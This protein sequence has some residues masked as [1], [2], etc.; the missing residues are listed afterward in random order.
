M[1]QQRHSKVSVHLFSLILI[2]YS[3]IDVFLILIIF[4]L[5][6][7]PIIFHFN[8]STTLECETIEALF[9]RCI[10]IKI[11]INNFHTCGSKYY[12]S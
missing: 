1:A 3:I 4:Q 6:F 5:L 10:I 8:N 2:T 7:S 11:L 12:K 9:Q